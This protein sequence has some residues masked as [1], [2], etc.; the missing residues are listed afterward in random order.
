MGDLVPS[1]DAFEIKG[2]VNLWKLFDILKIQRE[3]ITIFFDHIQF[4]WGSIKIITQPDVSVK[5]HFFYSLGDGISFCEMIFWKYFF[6]N[7]ET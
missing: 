3:R 4:P 2:D 7:Q 5:S 1:L 6:E